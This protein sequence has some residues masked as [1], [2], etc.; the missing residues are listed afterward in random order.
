MSESETVEIRCP[1]DFELLLER[2]IRMQ[3][4][5]PVMA[6]RTYF[7]KDGGRKVEMSEFRALSPADRKELGV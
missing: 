1:T 2:G 5:S 6:I 4:M 3:T 7:E